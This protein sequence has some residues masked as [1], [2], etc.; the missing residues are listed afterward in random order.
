MA[1]TMPT[2]PSTRIG[3][4]GAGAIGR[5][6]LVGAA[7]AQGV[8]IVGIADPSPAAKALAAEFGVPWFS[9]HR[10]L[11]DTTQPDGAIIATPNALHIPI[12][13]ECIA[14]GKSVLI[15]KPIADTEEDGLRLANAARA[16]DVPVL[17]G[18]HRRHNPIVR[19][20]RA[21]VQNGQLGRLVSA[22]VLSTILKP[23]SY[24]AQAW[25]RTLGAGPVLINLI[26]EIDL[27][28]FVCGDVESLQALTSNAVRGF[29]VED[30]AAVL[31]RL[32]NGAV[33]TITLSD[34]AAAPWAWDLTS[35]ENPSFSQVRP[36]LADSHFISG[37]EG[38]LSMPGLRLWR[39]A[40]T[41]GDPLERGWAKPLQT[42]LQPVDAG[43]PYIAQMAHFGAVIRREEPPIVDAFDASRT[44]AVT[45]AVRE[46]A[47]TGRVVRF[48]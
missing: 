16:A 41:P 31:L 21:I 44:L 35:G 20:A 46:A 42:D 37:T 39:Y 25:R 40:E 9:D 1:P 47:G 4:I 32:Q 24:Y 14:E 36:G 48:D 19:A 5:A 38:S 2:H 23:E 30:T 7:G 34:T 15:E 27:L 11:L 8:C 29:E 10:A 43:N 13:L 12:A 17:V 26:H 28:R 45:L 18:H 33:A 22:S 3:L 6:H